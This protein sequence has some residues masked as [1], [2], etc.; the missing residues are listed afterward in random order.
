MDIEITSGPMGRSALF[1]TEEAW[2]TTV[3][4][5]IRIHPYSAYAAP[6]ITFCV[7]EVASVAHLTFGF[8][9]VI[10]NVFSVCWIGTLKYI[11]IQEAGYIS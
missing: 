9:Q 2:S 1:I 10:G 5:Q 3:N 6:K 4:D 11:L 8:I 7:V